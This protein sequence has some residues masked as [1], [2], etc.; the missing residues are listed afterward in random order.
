[1]IDIFNQRQDESRWC[2]IR[3]ED[4]GL[5]ELKAYRGVLKVADARPETLMPVTELAADFEKIL[6][7]TGLEPSTRN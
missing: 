3:F 4:V 6:F 1:M 2:G 5:V 7:L